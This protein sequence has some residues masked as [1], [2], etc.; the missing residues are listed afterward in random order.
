[1]RFTFL[2]KGLYTLVKFVGQTVSGFT[3]IKGL[4]Y[5]GNVGHFYLCCI[6]HG[7]QKKAGIF[8]A[9]TNFA[10]ENATSRLIYT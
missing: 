1:M 6:T 2:A 5:L 7:S 3:P 4:L 9:L 10:Y 8:V